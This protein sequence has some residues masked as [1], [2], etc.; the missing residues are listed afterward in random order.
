MRICDEQMRLLVKI[1]RSVGQLYVLDFTIAHPIC[2]VVCGGDDAWRWHACFT[3][4]NFGALHKM[5][6]E[7]LA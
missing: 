5:G 3:Y 7:G 6:R 2:L 1:H 4:I